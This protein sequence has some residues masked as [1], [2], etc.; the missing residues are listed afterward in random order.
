[1]EQL[2]RKLTFGLIELNPQTVR[3][4]LVVLIITLFVLSASAPGT[5]GDPGVRMFRP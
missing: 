1:M 3:F 4:I 5:P 2:L